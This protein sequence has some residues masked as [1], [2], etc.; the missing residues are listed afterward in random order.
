EVRRRMRRSV[1]AQPHLALRIAGGAERVSEDLIVEAKTGTWGPIFAD[2]GIVRAPDGRAL[3][4]AVFVDS[5]PPYRG[6]FIAELT[7]RL[8]R[9]VFRT[10]SGE[11]PGAAR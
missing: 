7:E 1:A 9:S 11:S 10:P 2:A 4:L 3:V 5:S 6:S 8:A